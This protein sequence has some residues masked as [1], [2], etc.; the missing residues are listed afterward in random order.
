MN[1]QASFSVM[2]YYD[3]DFSQRSMLSALAMR[4]SLRIPYRIPNNPK[5]PTNQK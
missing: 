3:F 1:D 4:Q 2:I 5:P